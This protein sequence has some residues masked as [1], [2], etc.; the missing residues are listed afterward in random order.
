M[1]TLNYCHSIL[2]LPSDGLVAV[3]TRVGR[4]GGNRLLSEILD[5]RSVVRCRAKNENDLGV[6]SASSPGFLMKLLALV[7]T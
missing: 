5:P 6:F 4:F 3:F 7:L 1:A 2:T